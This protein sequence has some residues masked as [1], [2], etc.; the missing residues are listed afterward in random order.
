MCWAQAEC[1]GIG[2]C[3]QSGMAANAHGKHA[4]QALMDTQPTAIGA[5]TLAS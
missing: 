1:G 4:L 2:A 5:R 3:Q